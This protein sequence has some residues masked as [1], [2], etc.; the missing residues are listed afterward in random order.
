MP[1]G[2]LGTLNENDDDDD[3]DDTHF[4]TTIN[5]TLFNALWVSVS[6]FKNC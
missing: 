6:C 1:G 4:P 5:K 2:E 3:D